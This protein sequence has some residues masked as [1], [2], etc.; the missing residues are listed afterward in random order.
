MF[1]V[2]QR[3]KDKEVSGIFQLF[4]ILV[5]FS[6]MMMLELLGK[7]V[8]GKHIYIYF[9]K[10]FVLAPQHDPGPDEHGKTLHHL[11]QA[12]KSKIRNSTVLSV[13]GIMH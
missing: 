8:Y 7:F 1:E 13:M 5:G 6:A 10:Y 12:V 2:L 11:E 9:Y 4:G 3:G